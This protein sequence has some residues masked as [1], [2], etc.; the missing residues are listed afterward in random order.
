MSIYECLPV[1]TVVLAKTE[2][3]IISADPVYDLMFPKE[4][5][6]YYDVQELMNN[7][8][9]QANR[10]RALRTMRGPRDKIMRYHELSHHFQFVT[11]VNW[12]K[13]IWLRWI[14]STLNGLNLTSHLMTRPALLED[15][16]LWLAAL[17]GISAILFAI[18]AIFFPAHRLP[19]KST[20]P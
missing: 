12:S 15:P 1:H 2:S 7:P 3:G 20:V 8:E 6:G 14:E 5:G 9:I 13:Y 10:L 18:L 16:K 4:T 11:T 17:S 19:L